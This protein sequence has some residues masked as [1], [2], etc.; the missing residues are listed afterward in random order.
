MIYGEVF[1][2]PDH[3]AAAGLSYASYVAGL[4][5]GIERVRAETGVEGRMIVVGIRHF[6]EEAVEKA[7]RIM[8]E[9][10][11]PL[12][13]GFGLVGDERQGR[14]QDF[15]RAFTLAWEAGYGL[16]AHAGE[17]GGPE[18]VVDVLDN[19]A[20]TRI[21]HGVRAIED[22][23]LVARLAEEGTALEVCP[24]SNISLGLYADFSTHPIGRLRRGH[25]QFR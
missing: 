9:E 16:T 5:A 24:G 14:V 4:A 15:A 10:P 22:P 20:V 7:A 13:T 12:V 6:G 8:V 1:I 3:A 21:G 19:L 23:S 2:S 17:F 11:H 25:H 18:S